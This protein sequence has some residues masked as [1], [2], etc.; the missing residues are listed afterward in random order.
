MAD[1]KPTLA[2]AQVDYRH[3]TFERH[4]GN[5]V[6]FTLESGTRGRCDLVTGVIEAYMICNRWEARKA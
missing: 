1:R 3:G 5:C 4:C 2:K 6:M